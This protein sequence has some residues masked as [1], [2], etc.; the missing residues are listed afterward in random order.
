MRGILVVGS[1]YQDRKSN[2]M[3][4]IH[5]L[6]ENVEILRQ[7]DIYESPDHFG[8]GCKYLNIV[9]EFQT[10]LSERELCRK[11]KQFELLCGRNIER[12]ERGEVPVDID[13]VICDGV[14]VRNSD[15]NS[16]YFKKGFSMI[17]DF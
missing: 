7:S 15:Y 2:L 6:S 12:R 16:S 9:I 1:N 17:K 5:F 10:C 11:I 8:S 14:I 4:A 3:H 13:I